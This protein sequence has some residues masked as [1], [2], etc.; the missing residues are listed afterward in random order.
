MTV[1]SSFVKRLLDRDGGVLRLAPAWVPRTFTSPGGRLKLAPGDLYA[2]GLERGGICER[3]LASTTKADNGPL[4]TPDE[5]LSYIVDLQSGERCLLKDAVAE[6]GDLLLGEDVMETYGGWQVLCKFFDNSGPLPLHMHPGDEQVAPL[7][8]QGKPE[9]YYFPPQ[10]NA[11]QHSA[12]YTYFGLNPGTTKEE[13]IRCLQR[14]DEG[15]NGV[16]SLSRAYQ[17]QLG[18]GWDIPPGILHAPGSLVTYEPQRA[19]D[20]NVM[21][22]S[23]VGDRPI[24]REWLI[25]DV[26]P[27]HRDNL[28]AI[29][30]L[31]DWEANTAPDF[32]ER[33]FRP[34]LPARDEEAMKAEGYR[35]VWVTYG[36]PYF[37]A[38][39]LT[40]FPGRSVTLTDPEAY[41]VVVIQGY[42]RFGSLAVSSPTMIRFGDWTEDELFV[43]R[44]AARAGVTITN[45][46]QTEPLVLLKHF[47]PGNPEAPASRPAGAQ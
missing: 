44:P 15:D 37:S 30:E 23:L 5:G 41:G 6:L 33:Y 27:E 9:A 22:Q 8:K 24:P 11:I 14:W 42:G 45:A 26:P 19:S 31:I 34:P 25:K 7:G 21:F 4:T 36:S 20:V 1:V 18:T 13:F 39:E 38:K 40:V 3:W 32:K 35:E 16:L 29:V 12:P 17:L 2:Y 46:S 43:T 47:G 10:L 28:A